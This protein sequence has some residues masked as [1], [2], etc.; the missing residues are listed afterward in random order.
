MA[1]D[2]CMDCELL[3]PD[4]VYEFHHRVPRYKKFTLSG[5]S[6]TRRWCEIVREFNKCDMLCA[7]C[8]KIRH[9]EERRHGDD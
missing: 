1:G 2:M 7:N 3:M 6:L 8:H 4:Y 9:G 5:G